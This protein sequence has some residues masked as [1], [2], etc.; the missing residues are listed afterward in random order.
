MKTIGRDAF[1]SCTKLNEVVFKPDSEL[2]NIEDE[3]F[4]GSGL[5]K[6]VIPKNVKC[7]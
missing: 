3:C 7:I 6:I 5:R 2:K 1:S 4:S